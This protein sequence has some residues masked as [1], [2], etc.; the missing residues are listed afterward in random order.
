MS[1]NRLLLMAA[2]LA[3][4]SAVVSASSGDHG[5]SYGFYLREYYPNSTYSMVDY[6]P[7][8]QHALPASVVPEPTLELNLATFSPNITLCPFRGAC[9]STVHAT[10]APL[11]AIPDRSKPLQRHGQHH[12]DYGVTTPM[13]GVRLSTTRG[14]NVCCCRAQHCPAD[15]A[16]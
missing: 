12:S 15:G 5:R 9:T 10:I 11:V 13:V 6:S 1:R 3:A 8:Q 7:L 4:H 14:G 16:G 2:L